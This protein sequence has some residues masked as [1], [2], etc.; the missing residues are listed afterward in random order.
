MSLSPNLFT[1]CS[2]QLFEFS[3]FNT[4]HS[5]L[6]EDTNI[7]INSHN[8]NW[9]TAL[10]FIQSLASDCSS[11]HSSFWAVKEYIHIVNVLTQIIIPYYTFSF[12]NVIVCTCASPQHIPEQHL[13]LEKISKSFPHE[14]Q[15]VAY[16][17]AW[18]SAVVFVFGLVCISCRD[19]ARFNMVAEQR[20]RGPRARWHQT[21]KHLSKLNRLFL[22][23]CCLIGVLSA[24]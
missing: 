15:P 12:Q 20:Q 23:Q 13:Y 1:S 18:S 16:R 6:M 17:C 21:N 4:M 24:L 22:S 9:L 10:I 14:I 5:M 11:Y 2:L 7:R 8:I 19:G 3:E